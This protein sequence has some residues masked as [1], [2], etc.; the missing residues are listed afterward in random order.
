M[1]KTVLSI[2]IGVMVLFGGYVT[3][4]YYGKV[5][6]SAEKPSEAVASAMAPT[7]EASADQDMQAPPSEAKTEESPTP[8]PVPEEKPMTMNVKTPIASFDL[9]AYNSMGW[10]FIAKLLT[11]I[12]VTYGGI[13][14]I[15]KKMA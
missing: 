15:N 9:T 14:F 1:R 2:W 11:L 10:A 3:V 4:D 5:Y 7:E 12:L 6:K 13:R 8:V